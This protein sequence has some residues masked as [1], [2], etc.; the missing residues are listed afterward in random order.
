[1]E[2]K[3]VKY[4]V[5]H[6]GSDASQHALITVKESLLR[7]HDELVVAHAWNEAKEEYLAYNFKRSYIR[8]Q[9]I[10]D[11][12]YLGKRFEYLEEQVVGELTTKDVLNGMAKKVHADVAVV[13]YHGRKGPKEDPTLM[14]SAV[15]YLSTRSEAPVMII[16]DPKT[17]KD[18]GAFVFAVCVDGS[19]AS[20]N[21]LDLLI[22]FRHSDD[23]V[24]VIICEQQ[25]IDASK[26]KTVVFEKLEE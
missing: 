21:C 17:R 9:N 16:K 18:R 6:D 10:A 22:K 23:K 26:V 3:H 14:G 15:Q 2:S 12:T 24:Y 20:L 4:M 5:C 11:F 1:M 19:I 7:D 25:N 13:G 8:Q